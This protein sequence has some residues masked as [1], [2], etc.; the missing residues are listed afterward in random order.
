MPVPL[1]S[2]EQLLV[3]DA[4]CRADASFAPVVLQA[5]SQD[6]QLLAADRMAILQA[7]GAVEDSTIRS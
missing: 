3:E 6:A 4:S 2:V 7:A 5:A 1:T